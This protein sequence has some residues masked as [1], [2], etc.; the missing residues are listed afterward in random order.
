M[1]G[2]DPNDEEELQLRERMEEDGIRSDMEVL[3][4]RADKV[5]EVWLFFFFNINI[6]VAIAIPII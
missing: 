3:A 4:W 2:I 6:F 5:E 1:L